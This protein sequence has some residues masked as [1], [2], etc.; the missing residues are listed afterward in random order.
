MEAERDD[1]PQGR[2]PWPPEGLPIVFWGRPTSY[3]VVAEDRLPAWEAKM[4]ELVGFIPESAD[5]AQGLQTVS[6][7]SATPTHL[8][9]CDSDISH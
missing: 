6:F 7:C 8:D 9:D 1:V 4:K 2:H 3:E 5:F